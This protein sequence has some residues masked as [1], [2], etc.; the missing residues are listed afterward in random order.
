MCLSCGCGEPDD[1]H[2]DP[3]H[4]TTESL[5]AAATAAEITP[6]EAAENI[7]TTYREKV[8]GS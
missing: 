6:E 4:I 2:G 8:K 5:S 1:D 3:V 7:L